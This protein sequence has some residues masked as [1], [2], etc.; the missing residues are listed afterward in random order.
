MCA[1]T[2]AQYCVDIRLVDGKPQFDK[3][4]KVF[5]ADP[6]KVLKVLNDFNFAQNPP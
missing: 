3:V 4:A 2:M 6:S 5:E 1:D